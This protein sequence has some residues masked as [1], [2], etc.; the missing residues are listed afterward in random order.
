MDGEDSRQRGGKASQQAS[1]QQQQRGRK[2]EKDV[3][4]VIGRG[5]KKKAAVTFPQTGRLIKPGKKGSIILQC[6]NLFSNEAIISFNNI[7]SNHST[8]CGGT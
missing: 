5:K 4:V 7:M 3:T 6:I 1:S 8:P 2:G